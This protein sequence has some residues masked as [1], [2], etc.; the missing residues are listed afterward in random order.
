MISKVRHYVPLL[1]FVL[2]TVVIGYGFVIPRSC[3]HGINQLSIGF[4][5]TILGA[6]LAYIAG[7][8]SATRTSCPARA[9]WRHRLARYVNRQAANPHGLVGKLLGLIWTV[10]HR[11]VNRVT[12]D[13]LQIGPTDQVAEIGCGP[14]WAL[15][16][17]STIATQGHVLG[18]DVSETILSAARR[19]NRRAITER[20]ASV[21]R[22]DGVDLGL[23]SDTFD[24]VFSVH[25]IYFWKDPERIIAQLFDALRS[26]GQLVLAFRPDGSSVPA[27]FRDDVYRF[28][29]PVDVERMLVATGFDVRVVLRPEV[30]PDL[31]WVVAVKAE[32]R[33]LR[34]DDRPN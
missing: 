20:R 29:L 14:G 17:A 27:R 32:P 21:R 18:L 13:L 30:S 15:R 11:R 23:G 4:G 26:G 7:V 12:L 2:P 6:A 16:E 8:R 5:T 1:S 10:E 24:R 28:Y 25:S 22:I 9:P 34:G 33:T 31:V 3:I 19:A